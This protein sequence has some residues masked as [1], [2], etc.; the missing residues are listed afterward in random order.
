VASLFV[1]R[2]NDQGCRYELTADVVGVGRD[3]GNLVQLHDTEVSRRHAILRVEGRD[4]ILADHRSSNG[5]FVNG[6]RIETHRLTSGDEIQIGGSVLLF[7][8][9]ND[10]ASSLAEKIDIVSRGRADDRSRIVRTMPQAEG[11]SMLD[12]EPS[13]VSAPRLA[14]ARSNLEVMYRTAMAVSQTLDIDQLLHVVMELIFEWVECDRGC[15]ML[16]E[17]DSKTLDPRVRR[18][19]QSSLDDQRMTISKTILDHVMEKNEGVLISDATADVKWNSAASIV[20]AGIREA[21]CVPMQGRHSLVGLI[22]LD[23]STS[24]Q[25]VLLHGATPKFNEEHLRL[26]I[27]IAHQAALAVEDTRYYSAMVQSERLAA[28]GQA[29][30]CLSHHVKNILQGIRGGSYL[31][32]EGLAKHDERMVAKGWE[33]VEKNQ[34]RISHLVMDMLT[35]SKEREPEMASADL[36]KVVG[37]VVELMEGRA[38]ERGVEVRFDR[39]DFLPKMTFD[40]EGL[41]RAVLNVVSNAI[42][43][44]DREARRRAASDEEDAPE[45]DLQGVVGHVV[46]GIDYDPGRSLVQ[47][48]VADD[49]GGISPD[50]LE[51][52]FSLFVSNKGN[53]GTGLGL[54]VSQKIMK[55]HG[56][57][58]R[59]ESE[60]GRGATFILE[61]QAVLADVTQRAPETLLPDSSSPQT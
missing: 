39:P 40:P 10:D 31:M 18:N 1:V 11:R 33:F 48:R 37:D 15:V 54:P 3:A 36:G 34:E 21:L 45:P 49:G 53:R 29:I 27:A 12:P 2:G 47:V 25:Q 50:D 19:R 4:F 14:K 7:T 9:G 41:H 23:V 52:I 58:I 44:C 8:G 38:A 46:V 35:F 16:T 59:V 42:D 26:M 24:P 55:E 20:Q 17:G 28:V 6:R 43:A 57:T 51:H 13:M 30:A 56:G 61:M 60:L 5:T 22:Y 32:K